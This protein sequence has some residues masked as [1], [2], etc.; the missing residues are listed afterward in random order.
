MLNNETFKVSAECTTEGNDAS[1][2]RRDCDSLEDEY[3][4]P[5]GYT[6][7]DRDLKISQSYNGSDP[8][9]NLTWDNFIELV[10]GSGYK[11]PTTVRLSVHARSPRGHSGQRGWNKVTVEGTMF[12]LQQIKANIINQ[13]REPAAR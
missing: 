4:T 5:D 12:N 8:N 11:V 13:L 2:R 6:L 3:N 9:I 7:N 10:P 1:G